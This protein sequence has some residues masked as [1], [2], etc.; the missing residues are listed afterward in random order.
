MRDQAVAVD[1]L[2][3]EGFLGGGEGGVDVVWPVHFDGWVAAAKEIIM[4][5]MC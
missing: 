4:Y 2:A 1:G 5:V 3:A